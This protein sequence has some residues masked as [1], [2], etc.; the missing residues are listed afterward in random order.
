MMGFNATV[1]VTV[2]GTKLIQNDGLQRGRA[3]T[4]CETEL[5]QNKGI[6]RDRA[7]DGV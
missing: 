4:V 3:V 7:D 5:I 1:Q 2:C 6:Q